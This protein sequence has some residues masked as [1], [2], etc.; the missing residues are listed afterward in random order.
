MDRDSPRRALARRLPPP[1]RAIRSPPSSATNRD[2]G[3][4]DAGSRAELHRALDDGQGRLAIVLDLDIKF[5]FMHGSSRDGGLD[6]E[7]LWPWA[8]LDPDLAS[9]ARRVSDTEAQ[10]LRRALGSLGEVARD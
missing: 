2:L 3:A 6:L 1:S 5:G 4:T 10:V 7:L 9:F 8:S